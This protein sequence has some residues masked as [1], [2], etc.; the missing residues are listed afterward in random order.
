M[1]TPSFARI[2]FPEIGKRPERLRVSVSNDML[3]QIERECEAF[4]YTDPADWLFDVVLE[5][6]YG[7]EY[8]ERLYRAQVERIQKLMGTTGPAPEN[9]MPDGGSP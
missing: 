4:G 6:L 3:K 1:P 5:K 7:K 9:P 8:V 2:H